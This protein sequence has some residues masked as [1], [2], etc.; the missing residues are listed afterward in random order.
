MVVQWFPRGLV[1]LKM[2]MLQWE[3]MAN[4]ESCLTHRLPRFQL[5][6]RLSVVHWG[7]VGWFWVRVVAV[8]HDT[9]HSSVW[10]S[11]GAGESPVGFACL[12]TWHSPSSSWGQCLFRFF[13][14]AG[15]LIETE[16]AAGVGSLRLEGFQRFPWKGGSWFFRRE[17][18]LKLSAEGERYGERLYM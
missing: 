7:W 5:I 15:C 12:N 10:T 4:L 18:D 17:N 13:L 6:T 1:I 14:C 8:C 3:I 11:G 2:T 9:S 16:I